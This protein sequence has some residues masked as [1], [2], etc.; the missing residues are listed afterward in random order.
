MKTEF[1]SGEVRRLGGLEY[2][3][4]TAEAWAELAKVLKRYSKSQEHA[5]RIIGRFLEEGAPTKCPSPGEVIAM[6][7]AVPGDP[8]QDRPELAPPCEKC[9]P[10]EGAHQLVVRDGVEAMARCD[11]PRGRKLHALAVAAGNAPPPGQP[12]S[13]VAGLKPRAVPGFEKAQPVDVKQ[14]ASGDVE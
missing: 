3:P 4:Q 2:T 9:A 6:A 8:T 12:A 7:R 13:F 5:T 14:L 11:C 10:F 1:F